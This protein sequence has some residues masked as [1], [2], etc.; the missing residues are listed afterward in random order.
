MS[1]PTDADGD[2]GATG[3]MARAARS[4]QTAVGGMASFL[5][6]SMH[7]VEIIPAVD[8]DSW[9]LDI[10][11]RQKEHGK[12]T[13]DDLTRLGLDVVMPTFDDVVLSS[14][15][16][17]SITV[18]ACGPDAEQVQCGRPW[19]L[20]LSEP[21]LWD[22]FHLRP[23]SWQPQKW[24]VRLEA[25]TTPRFFRERII[26]MSPLLRMSSSL[27]TDRSRISVAMFV[28][29]SARG[30]DQ[31][32]ASLLREINKITRLDFVQP[33][34]IERRILC[35]SVPN[36]PEQLVE[37]LVALSVRVGI[38]ATNDL[39]V[40]FCGHGEDSG[41]VCSNGEIARSAMLAKWVSKCSPTC[42]IY[43]VCHGA[44]LA[45]E[46][47]QHSGTCS[48][49]YWAEKANTHACCELS[50]H[51]L[52]M[53]FNLGWSAEKLA[54]AFD[55]ARDV[56][57]NQ[58]ANVAGLKFLR[59]GHRPPHGSGDA[60][61]EPAFAPL[62]RAKVIFCGQGR[63]GKTS[64]RKALTDERFDTHESSTAGAQVTC[65][66]DRVDVERADGTDGTGWT[67]HDIDKS[68]FTEEAELAY[69]ESRFG[70]DN[71]AWAARFPSAKSS[72]EAQEVPDT[73][74]DVAEP[75]TGPMLTDDRVALA[76]SNGP[77]RARNAHQ[78]ER[79][80]KIDALRRQLEAAGD[81][82]I[83]VS[84]WDLGGQ[85]LF[86][87]LQQ[88]FLTR[89]AIYLVTFQLPTFL[90]GSREG[91]TAAAEL[92]FWCDMVG[93]L[94]APRQG[95]GDAVS[96]VVVGMLPLHTLIC[97]SYVRRRSR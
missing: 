35:P 67:L 12:P 18:I 43:N 50:H 87:A 74:E 1:Q 81:L 22:Q 23:C 53:A 42:V 2:A 92:R 11:I 97:R 71:A 95:V 55:G 89:S 79:R 10:V 28:S 52:R 57:S 41:L 15:E 19:E 90:P 47:R 73:M 60:T 78:E 45:T 96:I 7:K 58:E 80:A 85:R 4:L 17:L 44:K 3:F 84:M 40:L 20:R 93:A 25:N 94:I 34:V 24:I 16:I 37:D 82:P 49:V 27:H 88:L 68:G 65:A 33:V 69:L 59:P 26:Q 32:D 83:R 31:I 38:D 13:R 8:W 61:L 6:P 70:S 29:P 36:S 86:Q 46:T 75:A 76:A 64:L 48:I 56:V 91:D 14:T 72:T 66:V 9:T 21:S 54:V 30:T 5:A 39:V 51:M 77:V 63:T 62:R